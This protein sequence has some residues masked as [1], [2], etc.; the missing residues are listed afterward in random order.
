MRVEEVLSEEQNRIIAELFEIEEANKETPTEKGK[1]KIVESEGELFSVNFN[2][3][4]P[5]VSY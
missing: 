1:K 2:E 3:K 4:Y 5:M